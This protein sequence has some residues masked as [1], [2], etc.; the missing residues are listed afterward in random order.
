[1]KP[2]A[3]KSAKPLKT[4]IHINRHKLQANIKHGKNDPVITV[5]TYKDNL[6]DA[7][8]IHGPA[9]VVY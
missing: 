7:V 5:K 2:K 6:N 4:I 9:E 3:Q 8:K 1:M